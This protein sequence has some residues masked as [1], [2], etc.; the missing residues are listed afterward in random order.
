M[1]KKNRFQDG[2]ADIDFPYREE[3]ARYAHTHP[4][5]RGGAGGG[6]VGGGSRRNPDAFAY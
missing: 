4:P 5:A 1:V 2:G 3:Q 6:G